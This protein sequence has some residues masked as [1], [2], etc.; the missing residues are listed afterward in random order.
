MRAHIK[1]KPNLDADAD[2]S[3]LFTLIEALSAVDISAP[4]ATLNATTITDNNGG[5]IEL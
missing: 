2:S 5:R 4:L 3:A 1:P